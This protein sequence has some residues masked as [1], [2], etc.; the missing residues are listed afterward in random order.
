MVRRLP[1]FLLALLTLALPLTSE[2][3]GTSG[4]GG[5]S[6]SSGG[7]RSFSSGSSKS[8]TGGSGKSYSSGASQSRSYNSGKSY[9][10]GSSGSAPAS[11]SGSSSG[12]TFT[13]KSPASSG[14]AFDSGASRAAKEQSSKKDFATYQHN[15]PTRSTTPGGNGAGGVPPVIPRGTTTSSGGYGG[16]RS[17]SSTTTYHHTTVYVDHTIYSTRPYRM[18]S[19]YEP[20]YSR[21]IVIYHDNYSSFFWW[22]L[23]DRSLEDQ[24]LW[25]YHHRADMDAARYQALLNSNAA[26][27]NRIHQLETQQVAPNPSYTPNGLDQDLMYDDQTVN[28]AYAARPTKSG[29]AAFWLVM[30]PTAIGIT[31]LF[32]W[33]VFFKRW[34][35]ANA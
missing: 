9:G 25:A 2:A 11:G 22:W 4:G 16:N 32:G 7:S 20:Y 29:Q 26:L 5:R 33:L 15:D 27:E 24:A 12:S 14:P 34:R 1:V 19:Y 8:Y 23:L 18:R 30:V 17:S 10:S 28:R 35:T 13:R 3:R 31:W 21:P 6:Y